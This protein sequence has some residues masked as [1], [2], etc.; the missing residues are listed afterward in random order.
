MTVSKLHGLEAVRIDVND[1]T[2]ANLSGVGGCRLGIENDLGA[3]NT[4]GEVYN[5]FLSLVGQK[6]MAT[7]NTLHVGAALDLC[8]FDCLRISAT[9]GTKTGLTLYAKKQ[10]QGGSRASGSVHNSFNIKQGILVP[11]RLVCDHQGNARIDYDALATYDGSNNPVVLGTSVALPV[12]PATPTR[13]TL[14]P[15][16]LDLDGT[17]VAF[18]QKRGIELD[19]G[20]S[21]ETVGADSDIWDT[22]ARVVE[23]QPSLVLRGLD[24]DW[25]GSAAIPL[26]GVKIDY[27]DTLVVLRKRALGGTFVA[28]TEDEH[29]GIKLAGMGVI[30][31]AFDAQG[32]ATG[33]VNLR[34]PCYFDGTN[35]PIVIDTTY[36]YES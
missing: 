35:A 19:F 23:T 15:I 22:F 26:T 18:N 30:E 8:G 17:P 3:V 13:F 36:A 12:N 5:R 31:N 34:I 9:G 16:A 6:L 32:N 29:I 4:D 24:I 11:R 25:F 10:Q 2:T 33:E 28:G 14:G 1:A 7:F 21:V 20:H 27:A